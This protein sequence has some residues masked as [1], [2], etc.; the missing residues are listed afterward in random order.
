MNLIHDY[1]PKTHK[2]PIKWL[3]SGR[4]MHIKFGEN[5]SKIKQC[6][7]TNY[8]E[9]SVV[10]KFHSDHCFEINFMGAAQETKWRVHFVPRRNVKIYRT[11]DNNGNLTDEFVAFEFKCL[12]KKTELMENMPYINYILKQVN[13]RHH[14]I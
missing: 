10:V 11:P 4:M 7:T 13:G 1:N 12:W 3:N 8:P 14:N 2:T 6:N 5:E 9:Q